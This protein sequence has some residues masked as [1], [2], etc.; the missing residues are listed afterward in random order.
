M[1]EA[2]KESSMFAMNAGSQR[3]AF[4]LADQNDGRGGHVEDDPALCCWRKRKTPKMANSAKTP[5]IPP[6]DLERK[7]VPLRR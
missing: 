4:G 6:G 3:S 5:K 1:P 7:I 2:E